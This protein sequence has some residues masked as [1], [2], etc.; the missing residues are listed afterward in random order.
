[1][2][3]TYGGNEWHY[4]DAPVDMHHALLGKG[5]LA[6]TG[7]VAYLDTVC[8]SANAFGLSLGLTGSFTSLEVGPKLWDIFVVAHEIGHT[9]GSGHTHDK[10]SQGGYSPLVDTCGKKNV[11][12]AY[13]CSTEFPLANSATIMGYCHQCDG[14]VDNIKYTLGGHWTGG[15]RTDVTNW[16]DAELQGTVSTDPRRVPKRMYDV[17]STMGKCMEPAGE[18]PEFICES[19]GDCD[20]GIGC[21]A[22]ECGSDGRCTNEPIE[23]PC[24]GN[25]VCEA[26]ESDSPD[27]G[28]FH[29]RP[30]LCDGSCWIPKGIMFDVDAVESV[31]VTGLEFRLYEASGYFA[32]LVEVYEAPGTY[33]DRAGDPSSWSLV[34]SSGYSGESWD[35]VE[36]ALDRTVF[37]PAGTR[38]AF[39]VMALGDDAR[40]VAGK[41]GD[42]T[43]ENAHLVVRAPARYTEG[44]FGEGT[45]EPNG[46]ACSTETAI[47]YDLAVPCQGDADCVDVDG[48]TC[49]VGHCSDDGLCRHETSE[50][51]CGN[52]IC[53]VG[54]A[55]DCSGDCE[56]FFGVDSCSLYGDEECFVPEGIMVEI[57]SVTDITPFSMQLIITRGEDLVLTFHTATGSYPDFYSDPQ[58]WKR[59]YST[60]P[61]TVVNSK[62]EMLF[63]LPPE[64]IRGGQS[65]SYYITIS[66]GGGMYVGSERTFMN[67]DLQILD[68]RAFA[69]NDP[70]SPSFPGYSFQGGISYTVPEKGGPT[71]SPSSM[72]PTS[73]IPSYSPT[74]STYFPTQFPTASPTLLA[75]V[76]P[77][78]SSEPSATPP[79]SSAP[80]ELPTRSPST[81][82][83]TL[84]PT[85]IS[86]TYSHVPTYS[87]DEASILV[88]ID[89]TIS[90]SDFD[91]TSEADA[92]ILATTIMDV[93]FGGLV[94][95]TQRVFKV[96][97][98]SIDSNPSQ[99]TD[100]SQGQMTSILDI[101]LKIARDSHKKKKRE[102]T[103]KIPKKVKNLLRKGE[104]KKEV[105]SQWQLHD[106]NLQAQPVVY[107]LYVQELCMDI[108]CQQLAQTTSIIDDVTGHML[109][110]VSNGGFTAVLR[111]NARMCGDN[112]SQDASVTGVTFDKENTSVGINTVTP[113][114]SPTVRASAAPSLSII[115]TVKKSDEPSASL[116]PSEDLTKN[117]TISPTSS[118]KSLSPTF[119]PVKWFLNWNIVLCQKECQ[120]EYPC[121]GMDA[122]FWADLYDTVDECCNLEF[123]YPPHQ[124]QCKL[125]SK[126]WGV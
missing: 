116:S 111:N 93:S 77:T 99:Q 61:F 19:D 122:P 71:A 102:K 29:L 97:L 51:C 42:P 74:S 92:Q 109:Q 66:S 65:Q 70:L 114:L 63:D 7:G 124:E 104:P 24:S 62:Q 100:G 121:A 5:T 14:Y 16:V 49:T 23:G 40:V 31:V 9:L 25:R 106:R 34:G 120:G 72:K 52:G 126:Q 12:G 82:P 56:K 58:A 79:T 47:I 10:P 105:P 27:C 30:E 44:V 119:T 81:R 26:G 39:Y 73:A 8:S 80:S 115:P 60:S 37:V 87:F 35:R 32:A 38:R 46:Q 90:L 28:P 67:A 75:T 95:H 54:E 20:D 48:N 59:L 22:D 83:V 125:A 69:D 11:L 94:L 91:Y 57:R 3:D 4:L 76:P 36:L 13:E 84:A 96:E 107:I 88:S 1:M 53:E 21:T 18:V 110:E 112:C 64:M 85:S 17:V 103:E 68:V 89:A 6:G 33:A 101:D 45:T 78:L 86:P 55:A 15:D 113:T 41:K 123:S 98:L 2:R 117:P 50:N 43:A 108:P 118:S